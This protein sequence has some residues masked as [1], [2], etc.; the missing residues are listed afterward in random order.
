MLALVGVPVVASVSSTGSVVVTLGGE[1]S[2]VSFGGSFCSISSVDGC[3]AEGLVSS[4]SFS[5][6]TTSSV[7]VVV[8]GVEFSVGFSE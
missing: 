4:F 3:V 6:V 7:T 8:E 5:D 1:D 2:S